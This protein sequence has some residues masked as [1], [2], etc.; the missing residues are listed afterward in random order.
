[1]AEHYVGLMA[2]VRRAD[3]TFVW[4]TNVKSGE[5]YV[6]TEISSSLHTVLVL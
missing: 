2:L 4:G 1:M 5:V 3:V 6:G